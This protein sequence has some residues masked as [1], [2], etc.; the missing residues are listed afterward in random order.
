MDH[1]DSQ[2]KSTFATIAVPTF[3]W[4]LA[5]L[6]LVSTKGGRCTA[7]EPFKVPMAK[8]TSATFMKATSMAMAYTLGIHNLLSACLR[9]RHA[10]THIHTRRHTPACTCTP[11]PPPHLVSRISY[12]VS[13]YLVSLYLS[14]MLAMAHSRSLKGRTAL[15]TT[16]VGETG[17]KMVTGR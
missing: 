7:L 16:E 9:F 5:I 1:A 4:V 8:N 6:M 15:N 14:D 2:E 3:M 17:K 10:R 13:L 11:P 12:L